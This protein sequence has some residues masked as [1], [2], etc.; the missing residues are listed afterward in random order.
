MD[1]E[2]DIDLLFISISLVLGIGVLPQGLPSPIFD[3]STAT[4][5]ALKDEP[6][7]YSSPSVFQTPWKQFELDSQDCRR[8]SR[9]LSSL[10]S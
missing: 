10:F 7:L 8:C 4:E 2:S 6:D 9:T 3:I 1:F 5:Y